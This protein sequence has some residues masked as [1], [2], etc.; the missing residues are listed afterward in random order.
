ME[1]IYH[2]RKVEKLKKRIAFFS[3]D[4]TRSGGTERVSTMIANGLARRSNVE[5][6]I[7]SLVEQAKQPFFEIRDDIP[8]FTLKNDGKWMNPGLSYA[9]LIPRLRKFLREHKV[10]VIIDIDIVLDVLSIP[11]CV[12][13]KTKVI[14]WEHFNVA[15]EQSQLYRKVILHLTMCFSDYIVTLTE[16]DLESYRKLLKKKEKADY[17]YNPINM[18]ADSVK[19]A[20]M[21]E[22]NALI[23]MGRLIEVKGIDML[24]EVAPKILR[25]HR[26]WKWYILGEGEERALLEKVI[27]E[28]RLE[29]QLILTGNVTNV[30]AYLCKSSI[31]VMTSRHEG[32]P[33][34][35]LEA[36]TY[37]IP[38]VSF[39]VPTGPSEIIAD[40][41][42]GF[43]IPAFDVEQ[44]QE[45]IEQLIHDE[46]LRTRMSDRTADTIK[47]FEGEKILDK[48]E[49]LL[50]H[51][52]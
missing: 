44:M 40:G 46:A 7:L 6:M 4:I 20:A 52:L 38:C 43:L 15:H 48:W 39:D 36:M 50:L 14:S 12:G 22:R 42:N 30:G 29:N 49:Q 37:R 13:L 45:R 3:G 24:A 9:P 31:Y 16:R 47:K 27:R 26:D 11:A 41:Q 51:K 32:L 2:Q 34:S 21:E 33:M 28:N 5:V 25:E 17:I 19:T 18:T 23:T 10:D 8:C 35:L 1:I